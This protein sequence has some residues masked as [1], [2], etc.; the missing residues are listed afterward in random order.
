MK[1]NYD[2]VLNQIE[3]DVHR[4]FYSYPFDF[5]KKVYPYRIICII[6]RITRII[7]NDIF[8]M[9]LIIKIHKP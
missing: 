7:G 2:E 9:N 3:K 8:K 5:C 6:N 4:H 1:Q